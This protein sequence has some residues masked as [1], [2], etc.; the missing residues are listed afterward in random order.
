[1]DKLQVVIIDFV[2][3]IRDEFCSSLIFT[4]NNL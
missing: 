4:M 2:Y 3:V 1:M